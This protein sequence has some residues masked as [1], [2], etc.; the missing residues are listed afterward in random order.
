[1]PPRNPHQLTNSTEPRPNQ[2]SMNRM[3]YIRVPLF[4]IWISLLPAGMASAQGS[5][6]LQPFSAEYQLKRGKMIIGKVT[7]TLQLK[8]NGSY[9][10]TSVTIPVGLVAAFNSDKITEVSQGLIKGDKV[11]P[12]NYSYHHKRKKRPKLRKLQFNWATN[13][14]TAPGTKPQWSS[15]VDPGTQDRASK[16][17]TMM[18]SMKPTTADIQIQVVDKTKLK[19][20]SIQHSKPEQIKTAAGSFDTI[21]YNETKKGKATSSSFWLT[22]KLSYLPIKVERREKKNTFTM[23]LSKF[24]PQAR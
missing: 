20:Y 13:R 12:H 10:Y 16:I 4:L 3:H 15:P 8:P 19:N 2:L 1:M 11:I 22:P 23:T 17:L 21:K 9:T 5:S 6:P 7:T 14:V 18:L 24:N